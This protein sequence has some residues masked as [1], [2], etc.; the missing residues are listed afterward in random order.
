MWTGEVFMWAIHLPRYYWSNIESN[1]ETNFNKKEKIVI[2]DD[3]REMLPV[4]ILGN[5]PKCS[6]IEG[7]EKN[8]LGK[9][10]T[11]CDGCV[12]GVKDQWCA[13]K[14]W[15][16]FYVSISVQTV[17]LPL[18]DYETWQ[19]TLVMLVKLFGSLYI[20]K[21][22]WSVIHINEHIQQLSAP[23]PPCKINT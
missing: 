16:R 4:F 20:R 9:E 23:F 17:N 13:A 1:W 18:L 3:Q 7:W 12:F 14:V 15:L 10:F 2:S 22:H 21:T 5:K 8:R 11:Y 19:C 6:N